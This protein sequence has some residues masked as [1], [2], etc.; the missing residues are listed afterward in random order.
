V[1]HIFQL[2]TKYS[3]ALK[4]VFLDEKGET[5]AMEMGCYGIGVTRVVAAAIEQNHDERGI[6]FPAPMAPFHACLVPI[7][8][9]KSAAV[10]EAADRLHEELQA[11]G[12]E[13]LLDDRDERPGV[14]FADMD[15][16]GIPHRVVLSE[17]GLAAGSAEYKGRRDEK[18]R[19]LP[20][21]EVVAYLKSA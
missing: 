1:G 8:Y 19:D 12:V 18:P 3:E 16:I 2:R 5:R 21:Q 10:R 7:G 20:L 15:L 14:L 6:V 13:V 4:A 17:R 11:A 9:R